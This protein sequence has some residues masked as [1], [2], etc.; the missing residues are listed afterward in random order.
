MKRVNNEIFK[1]EFKKIN[2]LLIIGIV[3]V[4]LTSFCALLLL[5]ENN[6]VPTDTKNLN[7]IIEGKLSI[8]ELQKDISK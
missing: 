5:Y 7:E 1:K 8:E 4:I 2:N 3:F 6:R